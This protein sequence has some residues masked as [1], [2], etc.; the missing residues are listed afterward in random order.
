MKISFKLLFTLLLVV[1]LIAF[2]AEAMTFNSQARM[3]PLIIGVPV[4]LL[5]LWELVLEV[6]DA[7]RAREKKAESEASASTAPAR[8]HA[9]TL[10]IYAWVVAFFAT[11]YLFGFVLTT[12]FYPMLYMKFVGR[13]SW[14]MASA[15]SL[16]AVAFVYIVMVYALNVQLYDGRLVLAV[17][18]ATQGY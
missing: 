3:M 8:G 15:I 1:L 14:R 6:W 5:A 11:L 16:G 7:A 13:R 12:C 10:T 17:R 18:Q 2:V 9:H 4:L